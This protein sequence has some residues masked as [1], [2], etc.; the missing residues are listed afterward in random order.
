MFR[1]IGYLHV[2]TTLTRCEFATGFYAKTE[3]RPDARVHLTLFRLH[4]WGHIQYCRVYINNDYCGIIIFS[5]GQMFSGVHQ[6]P[7]KKFQ[8]IFDLFLQG[9]YILRHRAVTG[10]YP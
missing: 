1:R 8:P 2:F 7:N 3:Q 5:T 10:S 9:T 6:L 4:N